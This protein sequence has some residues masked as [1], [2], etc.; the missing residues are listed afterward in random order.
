[1]HHI[2]TAA[3]LCPCP[4]SMLLGFCMQYTL[5]VWSVLRVVVSNLTCQCHKFDIQKSEK[6]KNAFYTRNCFDGE[7]IILLF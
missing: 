1:M 6:R 3:M 4:S 7:I 5:V 2:P